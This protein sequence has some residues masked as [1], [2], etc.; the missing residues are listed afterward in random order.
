MNRG[1]EMEELDLEYFRTKLLAARA[2]VLNRV[3]KTETYGREVD[4]K[5]EAMDLLDQAA[6]AYSKEFLFTLSH[7]DRK[8]LQLIDEALARIE[9][10]TYGICLH[11]GEPIE[12]KRLEAV[13]W[14]RLC[15]KAQ[16]L[17]ERRNR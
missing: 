8:L 3:Q 11:T 14:A 12:P 9:S 2:E 5:S 10:G 7:A 16:E 15:I 13:P 6:V 1:V 17:E 4:T